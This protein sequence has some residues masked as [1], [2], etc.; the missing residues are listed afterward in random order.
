MPLDVWAIAQS[1]GSGGTPGTFDG[2]SYGTGRSDRSSFS[3]YPG[4]SDNNRVNCVQFTYAVLCEVINHADFASTT[5]V[6]GLSP[7]DEMKDFV[8]IKSFSGSIHD[9]V[10][11][12]DF[13]MQGPVGAIVQTDTPFGDQVDVNNMEPGDFCQYW[14]KVGGKWA[15]GH[16]VIIAS[17]PTQTDNGVQYQVYGAHNRSQS[18]PFL[19][20]IN[21]DGMKVF[22]ARIYSQ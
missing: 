21:F 7:T 12:N 1:L 8:Y 15:R 18:V 9:L 3:A 2:F 20:T 10:E 14:W 11:K 22:A 19:K 4:T 6:S 17:M 13:S 5:G 16:S